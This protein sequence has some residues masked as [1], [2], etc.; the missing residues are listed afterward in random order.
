MSSARRSRIQATASPRWLRLPDDAA[1]HL[2]SARSAPLPVLAVVLTLAAGAALWAVGLREIDIRA[3]NDLG[4]ISQA[5]P[6]LLSGLVL[7]AVAFAMS[8]R[9]VPFAPHLTL[10]SILL[11]I[12]AVHGLPT[13]VEDAPRYA[14]AYL[15]AAFTDVI[16]VTGHLLPELDGRFSWPLFFSSSALLTQAAGI[17]NAVA[18]QP[19]APIVQNI[20]YLGPLLVIFGALTSDRRL[21][22]TAAFIFYATSWIGQDYFAPQGFA[23]LL[24]LTVLAILLRWFRVPSGPSWVDRWIRWVDERLP[25][26]RAP[27]RRLGALGDDVPRPADASRQQRAALAVVVVLLTGVMV[28]SHQLTPFALLAAVAALAVLGRISLR[29]MPVLVAVMIG[30]WISYMTVPYLAGHL[31]PLLNDLLAASETAS[32]TVGERLAGSPDHVLIVQ[33]RLGA[34]ALLWALA[35]LG[36]IRRFRHG[37]VDIEAAALAAVPFGL[38]L[39]AAYGGEILLRV[40][41]YSLPFMAFLAAG[42]FFPT[43]SSS[44]SWG[45]ASR[46]ATV[47]AVLVLLLVV[48]KHGN[49]R[50]EWISADEVAGVERLYSMA[51]A[52]SMLASANG[53]TPLR[54][55]QR[56]ESYDF[57]WLEHELL[58]NDATA[59]RQTLDPTNRCAFLFLSRSQ[60]AAAQIFDDVGEDSWKAMSQRLLDRGHFSIAYETEDA[61]I[62]V[63]EPAAPEC[64]G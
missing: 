61:T 55:D 59:V 50:A 23:Y 15:H 39:L 41:L 21:V 27:A 30:I 28:G 56:M 31:V 46:L 42:L 60:Q 52:G 44:L 33:T 25:G 2:L 53:A 47:L 11:L 12:V 7:I 34:T 58:V 1:R 3:M 18:L 13:F 9:S 14:T 17:G 24:Y 57:A 19:W 26:L 8:Q 49:E 48:T 63:A 38:M 10:A 4:L 16:A 51:P 62:L 54:R 5:G 45:G 20:L 6:A 64:R 32:A 35:G 37:N 43:P 22:W 29:G 36:A 40:Y